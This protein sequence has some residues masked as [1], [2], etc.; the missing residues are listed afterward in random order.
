MIHQL[1]REE[2]ERLHHRNGKNDLF[3]HWTTLL[4]QLEIEE[5]EL[6]EATLWYQMEKVLEK[7]RRIE[8]QRDAMIPYLYKQLIEDFKEV[9]MVSGATIVRNDI[10]AEKS[11]V[12]VMCVVL[13]ELMNA[14]QPGHEDEEYDNFPICVAI[15]NILRNHPH[16]QLMMD[17]FFKKKRDNSGKEIMITPADPMKMDDVIEQMDDKAA[18][19]IETMEQRI[20]QLTAGLKVHFASHWE[21]WNKFCHKVCQDSEFLDQLY[22]VVPSGNEWGI[23]QKMICNM[24]GLFNQEQHLNK[25]INTLN[26]ALSTKQLRT[27]IRNHADFMGTDSVLC[28]SQHDTMKKMLIKEA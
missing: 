12:T 16:F 18:E 9:R 4:I 11:A 5:N 8:V 10:L 25:P 19:E 22:K 15:T 23:N 1:S 2:Q 27:Y 7:L 13:T 28:K 21:D 6:D 14:V 24:V 26:T 3:C 17:R 20:I